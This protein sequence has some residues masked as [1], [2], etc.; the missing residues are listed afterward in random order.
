MINGGD[1]VD[2]TGLDDVLKSLD[3][4]EL[5]ELARLGCDTK[6]SPET[7]ASKGDAATPSAVSR[8]ADWINEARDNQE[9]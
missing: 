2:K 9:K 1:K 8:L 4:E 3:D 7:Q 6:G 5:L